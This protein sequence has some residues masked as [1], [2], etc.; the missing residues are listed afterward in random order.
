MNIKILGK[1]CKNCTVL[2]EHAKAAAD[3]LNLDYT[4]DKV[5]DINEIA[6]FGVMHTPG[7]IVD[8]KI[9]SQG[10]VLSIEEIKSL[11]K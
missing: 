1:G 2:E 6:D 10:K 9:K 8:G 4:I 3:A 11:L 7:L 5:T